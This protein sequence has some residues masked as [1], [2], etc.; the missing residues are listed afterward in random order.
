[1]IKGAF[2]R[3]QG[4]FSTGPSQ[5][6]ASPRL[7]HQSAALVLQPFHHRLNIG[8]PSCRK[9]LF[10]NYT[11]ACASHLAAVVWNNVHSPQVKPRLSGRLPLQATYAGLAAASCAAP[12]CPAEHTASGAFA[13]APC[14]APQGLLFASSGQSRGSCCSSAAAP[15]RQCVSGCPVDHILSSR[16]KAALRSLTPVAG[17]KAVIEEKSCC[18][19][20]STSAD[21]HCSTE[22]HTHTQPHTRHSCT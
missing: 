11:T 2:S 16:S 12:P 8:Q 22:R 3:R 5:C 17:W 6:H 20:A 9:G 13:A 15:L 19:A 4:C 10:G 18:V 21:V 7:R 14:L 1:M